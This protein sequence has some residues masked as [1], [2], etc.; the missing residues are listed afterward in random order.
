MEKMSFYNT[1][2]LGIFMGYSLLRLSEVLMNFNVSWGILLYL[3][4]RF[5]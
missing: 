1:L 3:K 2:S 4:I 5:K